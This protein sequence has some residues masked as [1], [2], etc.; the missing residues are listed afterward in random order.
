MEP[1]LGFE[2]EICLRFSKAVKEAVKSTITRKTVSAFS[3][4]RFVTFEF[5]EPLHAIEGT[6]DTEFVS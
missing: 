2:P 5:V 6:A 1:D 4:G 3:E